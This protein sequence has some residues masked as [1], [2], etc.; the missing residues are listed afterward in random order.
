MFDNKGTSL[1]LLNTTKGMKLFD[2]IKEKIIFEK[3]TLE[4]VMQP[5]LKKPASISDDRKKFFDDYEKKG[6][7]YVLNVY[8][9]VS[10]KERIIGKI[11]K[12]IN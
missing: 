5:N 11:I 10:L 9:A 8:T 6:F 4:D 1:V 12:I 3:S 2:N 7:K